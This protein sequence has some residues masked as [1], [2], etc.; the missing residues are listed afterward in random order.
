MSLMALAA[1]S[2]TRSESTPPPPK[3][4]LDRL[5]EMLE[6]TKKPSPPPKLPETLSLGKY[7]EEALARSA[8]LAR[9]EEAERAR[10][11]LATKHD[12]PHPTQTESTPT[13]GVLGKAFYGDAWPQVRRE[14]TQKRPAPRT[15]LSPPQ[16]TTT[17]PTQ[18]EAPKDSPDR[19][20]AANHVSWKTNFFVLLVVSMLCLIL[21]VSLVIHLQD[22]VDKAEKQL[23]IANDM[24]TNYRKA[25][26]TTGTAL[27]SARRENQ[28]LLRE[29]EGEDEEE[30]DTGCHPGHN[31]ASCLGRWCSD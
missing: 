21:L 26:D 4:G 25:L 5:W 28:Q 2:M 27:T 15:V 7:V 10:R 23:K 11:E 30:E 1:P 17:P 19:A 29:L 31:S 22:K 24:L 3:Q 14:M 12:G 16:V 20:N 6:E 13:D 8:E 18:I 9:Q